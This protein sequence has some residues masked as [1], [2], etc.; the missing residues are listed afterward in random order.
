MPLRRPARIAF[1]AIRAGIALF[2]V[3]KQRKFRASSRRRSIA[4]SRERYEAGAE[5]T[6][7]KHWRIEPYVA[8]QRDDQPSAARLDTFGANLKYFH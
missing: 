7:S 5:I 2:L 8:R 4:W 1:V 3:R 6:L